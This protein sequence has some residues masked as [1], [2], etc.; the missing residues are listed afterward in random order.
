MVVGQFVQDTE[1]V[2]VGGGP[3]GL[4][5]A[6]RA[7]ELGLQTVLVDREAVCAAA[8]RERGIEVIAGTARF[9]D[10]RQL[11]VDDGAQGRFRFKHA[12][13][14]PGLA[15]APAPA[16][17]PA[18]PALL[19]WR[20]ALRAQ[21][22]PAPVLV[23][24]GDALALELASRHAA[25]GRAVALACEGP[26]LLPGADEALVSIILDGLAQRLE[27]VRLGSTI[28]QVREATGGLE[29]TFED[30]EPEFIGCLVRTA[31]QPDVAD[32]ALDKARVELTDV[33]SIRIDERCVTSNRR[34]L[35]AGTATGAPPEAGLA[36]YQG[37]IAAEVAGGQDSRLDARTWPRV[38]R[39]QPPLAWCGLTETRARRDGT[40]HR[41]LEAKRDPETLAR[42]VV[43]PATGVVL[44]LGLAGEGAPEAIA[45]GVLAVEMGAVAEDLA[46]LVHGGGTLGELTAGAARTFIGS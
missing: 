22:L 24:G 42:L 12:I 9:E 19:D 21:T 41:V 13:L 27:A 16:G 31:R 20:Q 35:A 15:P 2:V 30:A 3:A 23:V 6:T 28:E 32:L 14:A 43:E 18:G 8:L 38:V 5:A 39:T 4:A 11:A 26:H 29:V 40:A 7:A 17:W 44:G 33:G 36:L 46:A 37:R 1:C 10:A 45:L 34:V 25:A